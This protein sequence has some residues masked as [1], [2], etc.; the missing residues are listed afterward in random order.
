MGR[1][2]QASLA[3]VDLVAGGIPLTIKVKVNA[4]VWRRVRRALCVNVGWSEM[5][6]RLSSSAD[7][8]AVPT[9]RAEIRQQ[10]GDLADGP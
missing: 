7:V 4:A 8:G 5:R 9:P 1:V 3:R 6:R 10:V 2:A